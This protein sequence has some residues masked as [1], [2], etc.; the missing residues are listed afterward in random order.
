MI[1]GKVNLA[2]LLVFFITANW[3]AASDKVTD[4]NNTFI[5]SAEFSSGYE[6]KN[7]R[8][9]RERFRSDQRYQ[10]KQNNE[11]WS[12]YLFQQEYEYENCGSIED[13]IVNCHI[14][15]DFVMD[16]ATMKF[17][18]TTTMSYVSDTRRN[19]DPVIL[20]LGTCVKM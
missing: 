11:N 6:L 9:L 5:C 2:F 4:E 20:T 17:S 13:N 8:W 14:D 19:R 3:V 18:F 16:L 12:I 1:V 15:G 7:G 10:V